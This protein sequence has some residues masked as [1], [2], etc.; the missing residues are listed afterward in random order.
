MDNWSLE[1]IQKQQ[2]RVSTLS[3]K[4]LKLERWNFI[5]CFTHPRCCIAKIV[6]VDSHII[7]GGAN[8]SLSSYPTQS[9]CAPTVSDRLS[10]PHPT[11][12]L[13]KFSTMFQFP[14][15]YI[16]LLASSVSLTN[17]PTMFPPSAGT[18]DYRLSCWLSSLLA[19]VVV[20]WLFQIPQK[21]AT[22]WLLT[23][24]RVNDKKISGLI[25]NPC[26]KDEVGPRLKLEVWQE[27]WQSVVERD[28]IRMRYHLLTNNRE[29]KKC[30]TL[31]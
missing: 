27:E 20:S 31:L 18:I 26:E 10:P 30:E 9:L 2:L 22:S 28:Y 8:T 25:K 14:I 5:I 16:L 21:T 23:L 3:N 17:A 12:N 6:E 7:D 11:L 4:R 1:N 13:T 29:M 24:Y 15:K 19:S